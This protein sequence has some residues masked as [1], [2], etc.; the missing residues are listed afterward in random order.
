MGGAHAWPPMVMI[1]LRQAASLVATKISSGQ[2]AA[3]I[4]SSGDCPPRASGLRHE[5]WWHGSSQPPQVVASNSSIRARWPETSRDRAGCSLQGGL[6]GETGCV[7]LSLSPSRHRAKKSLFV[8]EQPLASLP[9]IWVAT[10]APERRGGREHRAATKKRQS[11]GAFSAVVAP[12]R[13]CCRS[14]IRRTEPNVGLW[15]VVEGCL[16]AKVMALTRASATRQACGRGATALSLRREP[17]SDVSA[18]PGTTAGKDAS[19]V[20]SK[21]GGKG[22]TK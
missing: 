10:A 11:G 13:L 14:E 1:R 12:T 5:S 4:F 21:S 18:L 19:R 2:T 3:A 8:L 20:P 9:S 15:P 6:G 22:P 7:G 17:R 16:P